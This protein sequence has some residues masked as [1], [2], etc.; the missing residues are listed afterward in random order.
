[1]AGTR[2][3]RAAAW[4]AGAGPDGDEAII[5]LDTTIVRTKP[6]RIHVAAHVSPR[7]LRLDAKCPWTPHHLDTPQQSRMNLSRFTH[8]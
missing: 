6:T 5:D 4:A 3:A 2:D 1:L 8:G 7:H